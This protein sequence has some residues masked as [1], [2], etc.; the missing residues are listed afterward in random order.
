MSVITLPVGCTENRV[1]VH[2][3]T[4]FTMIDAYVRRNEGQARVIGT[5]LGTISDG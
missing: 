1:A 3:A 2:P 4:L 5:L